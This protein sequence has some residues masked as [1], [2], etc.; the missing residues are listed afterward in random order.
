M[1]AG[2]MGLLRHWV[3]DWGGLNTQLMLWTNRSMSA[4]WIGLAR[5]SLRHRQLLGRYPRSWCCRCSWLPSS[6]CFPA[7]R[8]RPRLPPL[9]TDKQ[10]EEALTPPPELAP[11]PTTD[12]IPTK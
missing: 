5:F 3:Y 12:P 9:L 1:G 7:S 10:V 11:E 4:D 6:W 8:A 2:D